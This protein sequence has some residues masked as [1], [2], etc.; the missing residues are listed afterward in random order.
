[1]NVLAFIGFGLQL[2]GLSLWAGGLLYHLAIASPLAIRELGNRVLAADYLSSCLRRFHTWEAI[3]ALVNLCGVGFL[4]VAPVTSFLLWFDVSLVLLMFLVFVAY[5]GLLMPR[6]D[7]LRIEL[8]DAE[9]YTREV[10]PAALQSFL[11]LTTWY[12]R[13]MSFNVVISLVLL[14]VLTGLAMRCASAPEVTGLDASMFGGVM[15]Q[16]P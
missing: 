8:H 1:M 13:L 15:N 2:I 6:I 7:T 14:L 11:T 16:W 5:A 12:H 3:C 4:Y 9:A 10:E